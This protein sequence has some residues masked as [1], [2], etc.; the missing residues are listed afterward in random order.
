[1]SKSSE[2]VINI[3]LD[4]MDPPIMNKLFRDV[5]EIMRLRDEEI[6]S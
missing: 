5:D 6:S 1:M 4:R 2:K 3:K